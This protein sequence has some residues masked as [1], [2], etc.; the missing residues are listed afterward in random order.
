MADVTTDRRS[1]PRYSLILLAE[2]TDRLSAA[3][4]K[5]RTSDISRTGCYLDMLNP[6]PRGTDVQLR[7]TNQDEV[8]E[9]AA[10]VIYNSPGLGM[11]VKFEAPSAAQQA[12]LD[13]WLTGA[14]KANP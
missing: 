13:R 14:A 9:T 3:K 7:L 10:T 12:L 4:F 6:L 2:V 11:G 8:F 1:A 5:A